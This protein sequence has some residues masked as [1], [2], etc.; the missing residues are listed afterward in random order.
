MK[1]T[2]LN[3]I[4]SLCN[5]YGDISR[6]EECTSKWGKWLRCEKEEC[7]YT[8]QIFKV[9]SKGDKMKKKFP[10]DRKKSMERIKKQRASQK[11]VTFQGIVV[12]LSTD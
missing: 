1:V 7:D 4:C 3:D 11:N 2:K 6:I 12:K 10:I 8:K 9:R 5:K